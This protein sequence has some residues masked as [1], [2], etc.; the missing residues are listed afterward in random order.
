MAIENPAAVPPLKTLYVYV[1]EG[2]NCAC[3][4]CWIISSEQGRK[5]GQVI[6][7]DLLNAAI[8][9]AKPLGLSSIKWTGGEPT[10]HPDFPA[11]LAIQKKH[12]L[13]GIMESNGMKITPALARTL[14]ESGVTFVSVSLDGAGPA[15][16]DA[17]RGV[18]GAYRR[19]MKGICNLTEAGLSTQIILT[20]MR[21]NVDELQGLLDLAASL[22]ADSV[23][24]NIVQPTLRGRDLQE[25]GEALSVKELLELHDRVIRDIQPRTP[26]PIYFDIPVAFRRLGRVLSDR[27]A[28]GCG[29]KGI[30][31][32]LPDGHY[33]LCGIG[34]QV[35]ELVFGRAGRQELD[36][37]W[38]SHPVLMKIRE[39][40]PKELTGVCGR[41]LM[42]AVCLGSCVAQNYYRSHDL[43]APYWFCELAEQ[44]G[45]L[46]VTRLHNQ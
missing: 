40:I 44:E 23:K 14:K 33:A 28:T 18:K 46:P 4:H 1:T 38:N 25:E 19:A 31:G 32:L 27:G 36:G 2:C 30:L 41:C 16:H 29:I 24:L 11:L 42:K 3:R 7:P 34:Q 8:E 12:G 45:L 6:S 13:S 43:L 39:G 15:T 21:A 9:E 22:G 17:I 26:F 35:P 20:L 37:I 10:F 5:R